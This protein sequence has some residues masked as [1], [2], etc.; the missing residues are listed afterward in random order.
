MSIV[1]SPGYAFFVGP[2]KDSLAYAEQHGST[3]IPVSKGAR[4]P[5][6]VKHGASAGDISFKYH[7]SHNCTDHPPCLK[8]DYGIYLSKGGSYFGEV[9]P[10]IVNQP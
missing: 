2:G 4:F 10:I 9:D 6:G 5:E 8:S 1:N 3:K 7:N